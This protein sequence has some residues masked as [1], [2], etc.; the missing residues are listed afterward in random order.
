MDYNFDALQAMD[1]E[2]LRPIAV[3]L[4]VKKPSTDKETLIFQ[5]LDRQAENAAAGAANNKKSTERKAK[6]QKKEEPKNSDATRNDSNENSSLEKTGL[7]AKEDSVP[8]QK[9][10]PGRKPSNKSEV[11]LNETQ[12]KQGDNT[13]ETPSVSKRGRKKKVQFNKWFKIV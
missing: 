5:I 10:K 9:K 4:G 12:D 1:Q 13:Q 6:K 11:T 3:A 7:T 8:S 2:V